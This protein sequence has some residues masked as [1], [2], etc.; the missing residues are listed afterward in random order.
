MPCRNAKE[1][2]LHTKLVSDIL[3]QL[4]QTVTARRKAEEKAA[5]RDAMPKKRSTRLQ[6]PA[7]LPPLVGLGARWH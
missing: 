6:V 1:K 7:A 2:L 4:E 3:P 5:L